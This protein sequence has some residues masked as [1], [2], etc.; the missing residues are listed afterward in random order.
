MTVNKENK[1]FTSYLLGTK[2]MKTRQKHG[3]Q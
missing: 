3:S 1:M 2:V